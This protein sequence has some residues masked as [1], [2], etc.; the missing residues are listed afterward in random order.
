MN[1][2][3]RKKE[4]EWHF[5]AVCALGVIRCRENERE[6]YNCGNIFITHLPNYVSK[7]KQ[8]MKSILRWL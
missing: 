2:Q 3:C 7:Y 6:G 5:F 8:L 1:S 4:T